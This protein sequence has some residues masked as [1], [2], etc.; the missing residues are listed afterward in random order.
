MTVSD[1]FKHYISLPE[2]AVFFGIALAC[3]IVVCIILYLFSH[4]GKSRYAADAVEGVRDYEGRFNFEKR[5]YVYHKFQNLTQKFFEIV[6]SGNCILFFMTVYYLIN[7]FYT[8]EPGKT[9]FNKYSSFILLLLIVF[10]CILNTFLDRVFVRLNHVRESERFS[11]RILGMLYMLIIFG[12]IKFIYE[13]DNYDMYI[14]YFLGLMIGRFV[15]FDASFKD[16]AVNVGHA[17]KN[18]PIMLLALACTGVM[19]YWGFKTKFL[20]KHIGVVTNV[21]IAHIFLIAAIFIIFHIH[22][23]NLFRPKDEEYKM[24]RAGDEEDLCDDEDKE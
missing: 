6:F 7:R 4:I 14:V 5:N 1:Y 10:S 13:N 21:F 16:F 12:Y 24:Y 15:Y 19:A 9:F 8:D 3:V 22:P 18:F 11:I 2:A 17:L 20:I 23:E